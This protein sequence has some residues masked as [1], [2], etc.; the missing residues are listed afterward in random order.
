MVRAAKPSFNRVELDAL[1]TVIRLTVEFQT[2]LE[3]NNISNYVCESVFSGVDAFE[4]L[5]HAY[6]VLAGAETRSQLR[7]DAVSVS[8]LKDEF[9]SLYPTFVSEKR[10]EPRC[11]LLLELFKLQI[12]LSAISYDYGSA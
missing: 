12:S 6:R 4:S 7:W 5:V 9:R 1:R 10:F 3:D 8:S 11:R 2:H